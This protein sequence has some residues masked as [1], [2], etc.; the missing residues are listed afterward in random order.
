META[1]LG[2]I[3]QASGIATAASRVK[4]AA[5]DRQVLSFG[6][7]RM[8]PALSTLI[9][10]NAFVG[11]ADGVSVLR[12]ASFL[13][14]APMGTMPHA[15]VLVFGDTVAAMRA[16]DATV[17]PSV[18]RVCLID[19]AGRE[20]HDPS[21]GVAGKL[22]AC[23]APRFARGDFRESRRRSAELDLRVPARAADRVGGLGSEEVRRFATWP[24]VR[25]RHR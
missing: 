13:G 7:R 15:L 9:D 20:A 12:S 16:F 11:G 24:T 1:M 8:H 10:R 22:S 18:P 19:T 6:A 5:G 25:R 4:T 21:P 14:E 23:G 3:C 2:M 17:D